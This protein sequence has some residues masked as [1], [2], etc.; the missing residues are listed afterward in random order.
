M[1]TSLDYSR[2]DDISESDEEIEDVN[3]SNYETA[4]DS[5]KH[6][7]MAVQRKKVEDIFKAAKNGRIPALKDCLNKYVE[8]NSDMT[9]AEVIMGMKDG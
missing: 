5:Q 4:D 9:Q 6:K 2:F 3:F 8:E 1:S 7:L